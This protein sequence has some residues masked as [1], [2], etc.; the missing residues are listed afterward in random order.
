MRKRLAHQFALTYNT[1]RLNLPNGKVY[2]WK[3]LE[4]ARP[5]LF[6]AM[7]WLSLST[8]NPTVSPFL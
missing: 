3:P 5:R 2:Q 8:L 1:L 6:V 7:A 4:E